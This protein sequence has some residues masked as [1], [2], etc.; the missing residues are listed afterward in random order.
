[1]TLDEVEA[2]V[3]RTSVS[4]WITV[5]QTMIDAFAEATGDRQFIHIDPV[6]AAATPF[7]TTIAHGFLT[8]SLLPRLMAETPDL[9][10]VSDARMHVNY[11]GNR[12]RFLAPV[13]SGARIRAHSTLLSFEQKRPCQYQSTAEVTI[14][15]DGQEKPAMLAEWITQIFV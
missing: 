5:T 13:P 14:E 12:V 4:A 11:G 2:A 9:P 10:V 8:L 7:G 15:I 6:R 1:M 3:G